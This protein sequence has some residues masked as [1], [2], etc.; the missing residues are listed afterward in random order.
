MTLVGI[1]FGVLIAV[2]ATWL[3]IPGTF[4]IAVT[5]L[6]WGW[7][8]DFHL[9][10]VGVILVLVGV[11]ILL[12]VMELLL[13]GIAARYY[14]GSSRSAVCAIMGGVLGTIVGA[15]VLLLIGALAGLLA[16]SYLGAF[17]SEAMSGKP[18]SE[19]NRVALGTV[20]GNVASKGI[21]STAVI[22]MGIWI[23]T[24]ITP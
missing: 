23:Y 18:I 17:L 4:L 13:G 19:S 15:G 1:A 14:G 12:E 6:I 9:V 11:S 10:T 24:I 22:L 2:C 7:L 5:M 3:G 20:L 21:K 16:G 8:T